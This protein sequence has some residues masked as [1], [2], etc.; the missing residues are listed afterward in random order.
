MNTL[1]S[2]P[3]SIGELFDKFSI[4]EIKKIKI[5][6]SDK[7]KYVDKELSYLKQFTDTY[8]I[9]KVLYNQLKDINLKLWD[10]EDK[11]RIKECNTEFDEEFIELAR[12]V[13]FVNDARSVVKKKINVVFN[14]DIFE[15]KSYV[16]YKNISFGETIQEANSI[17]SADPDKRSILLCKKLLKKLQFVK[18]KKYAKITN[19]LYM[20]LANK[21]FSLK[22]FSEALNIYKELVK[23]SEDK[24]LLYTNMI[25]CLIHLKIY[26]ECENYFKIILP[27][28]QHI[29][30]TAYLYFHYYFRQKKYS[31]AFK[32]LY[33][34]SSNKPLILDNNLTLWNYEASGTLFINLGGCGLGD[35]LN[36]FRWI[37]HLSKEYNNLQITV[38]LD[39]KIIHLFKSHDNIKYCSSGNILSYDFYLDYN[40]I[41]HLL[42]MKR[43]HY[44]ED[45]YI[46]QN[47]QMDIKWN[48]IIKRDCKKKYT[49]GVCWKGLQASLE[50]YIPLKL[51][52]T[53]A[54]LDIDIIS[55]Q[56]YEGL[57]DIDDIDFKLHQFNFDIDSAFTDTISILKNIDLLITVDTSMV[58]LAG[59]LNINTW[60]ILGKHHSWQW[61]NDEGISIWYPT[62]KIFKSNEYNNWVN[63]LDKVEAELKT[64]YQ[65]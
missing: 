38:G 44:V 56:K 33:E 15:V 14:S 22:D 1:P 62:V 60:L 52:N 29:L 37:Q 20:S 11:L 28:R 3:I 40:M 25:S 18:D 49:I 51:F 61:V 5:E 63:I 12:S 43:I 36:F 65:L 19:E 42:N 54:N 32:Y 59:L 27:N 2:I 21:Y 6:D 35:M 7:L 13:Y 9:D 30:K 53:I 57:D 16:D 17:I 31:L 34:S 8:N 23:T 24:Y 39:K 26:D 4:L 46:L 50:K 10:I 64:T 47:N 45:C 48:K 55:L 58:H 41:P